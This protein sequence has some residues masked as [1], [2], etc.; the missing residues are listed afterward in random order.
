MEDFR[1]LN[2]PFCRKVLEYAEHEQGDDYRFDMRYWYVPT[3]RRDLITRQQVIC[4]STAC[5]AGTAA[6]LAPE[7]EIDPVDDI[8]VIDNETME[9]T[10]AG[11]K[12]MGL[13]EEQARK[14]FIPTEYQDYQWL[15]QLNELALERLRQY[16]IQAEQDQNPS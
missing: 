8:V 12:L 10:A 9:F 2:I 1:G 6:M 13:T 16:I 7:A 3:Y 14:L 4:N 5:L 15:D 11:A